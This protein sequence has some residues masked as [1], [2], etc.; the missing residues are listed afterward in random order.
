MY[1]VCKS[2]RR[3]M[4]AIVYIRDLQKRCAPAVC[5]LLGY[6]PTAKMKLFCEKKLV[7]RFTPGPGCVESLDQA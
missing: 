6:I 1:I 3:P 2:E 7:Y 5:H 4:Q